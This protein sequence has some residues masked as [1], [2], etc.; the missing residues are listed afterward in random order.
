[1]NRPRQ[2]LPQM[3]TY[4]GIS[5]QYRLPKT[6]RGGAVQVVRAKSALLDRGA[7]A[8]GDRFVF[9]QRELRVALRGQSLHEALPMRPWP[10]R[11]TSPRAASNPWERHMPLLSCWRKA[12]PLVSEDRIVS[13]SKPLRSSHPGSI[14]GATPRVGKFRSA[15]STESLSLSNSRPGAA[16]LR[17]R[18]T[19]NRASNVT[20]EEMHNRIMPIS[21]AGSARSQWVGV[22]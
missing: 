3:R 20:C 1:M 21:Q 11:L 6:L 17:Y 2:N 8:A 5:L 9:A 16:G 14:G 18:A 22:R 15:P 19:L 4:S 13:E 7:K 10:L 12:R